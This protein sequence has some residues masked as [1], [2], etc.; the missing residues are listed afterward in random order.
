MNIVIHKR[1]VEVSDP[2]L[3]SK[4]HQG[5]ESFIQKGNFPKKLEVKRI[6]KTTQY[7]ESKI[8]QHRKLIAE[9]QEKIDEL[10]DKQKK[11]LEK[12]KQLYSK[13]RSGE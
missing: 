1:E 12:N 13:I 3:L 8:D 7:F 6:R 2:Q 4:I 11:I 10:S 5:I 9:A